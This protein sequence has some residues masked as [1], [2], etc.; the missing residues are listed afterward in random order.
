VIVY[1]V[2]QASLLA[3]LWGQI[4]LSQRRDTDKEV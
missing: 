2:V 4:A 3:L 1:L